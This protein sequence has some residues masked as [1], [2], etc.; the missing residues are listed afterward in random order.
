M[1]L[2]FTSIYALSDV[3]QNYIRV[4][5]IAMAPRKVTVDDPVTGEPKEE[6]QFLVPSNV[7]M[8]HTII[9][10]VKSDKDGVVDIEDSARNGDDGKT[11]IWRFEPLSLKIWNEMGERGDIDG[12]EQ[13]KDDMHNDKDVIHFYQHDWLLPRLS[14]WKEAS[15]EAAS[16]E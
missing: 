1:P 10:A 15:K 2:D 7:S 3:N 5:Q 12:W 16:P 11:I 6:W 13:I 8:G 9:G 4:Q 14:W